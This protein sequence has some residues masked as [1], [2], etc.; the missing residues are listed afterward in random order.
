MACRRQTASAVDAQAAAEGLH[1]EPARAAAAE[2]SFDR[3]PTA[4]VH[5]QRNLGVEP[6]AERME[7]HLAAGVARHAERDVAAE[8]I[9]V[10]RFG[11]DPPRLLNLD[12]PAER[13]RLNRPGRVAKTNARR[14]AV[15]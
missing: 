14:E 8:G 10:D 1:A 13:M 12:G 15:N 3:P 6:T 7:R 9:D 4:A 5:R 2:L 11:V